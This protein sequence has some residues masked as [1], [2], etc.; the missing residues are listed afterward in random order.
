MN[1]TQFEALMA[2]STK[3]NLGHLPL[4]LVIGLWLQGYDFHENQK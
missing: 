2:Y 3:F 4:T 1:K